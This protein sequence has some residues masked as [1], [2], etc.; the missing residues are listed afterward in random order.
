M[1]HRTPATLGLIILTVIA[2][3]VLPTFAGGLDQ[4]YYDDNDWVTEQLTPND[5]AVIA[6]E[7]DGLVLAARADGG[8][9]LIT[10]Y[11]H[12]PVLVYELSSA[13]YVALAQAG[14]VQPDPLGICAGAFAAARADGGLEYWK[15]YFDPTG[16]GIGSW[17]MEVISPDTY[18]A[19]ANV[20]FWGPFLAIRDDGSL[21]Y[22]DIGG[23]SEMIRV[24]LGPGPYLA[25][26]TG[27]GG[28]IFASRADGGVDRFV[29]NVGPTWNENELVETIGS[30]M[31]T[32]MSMTYLYS[33]GP[34]CAK[35]GGGLYRIDRPEGG[36]NL[37]LIFLNSHEYTALYPQEWGDHAGIRADGTLEVFDEYGETF[38]VVG[39]GKYKAVA[40][41]VAAQVPDP[42][43]WP[44]D[45]NKDLVVDI[46]DLN[47]I[48]IAWG[49]TVQEYP[50][51]VPDADYDGNGVIN[52]IDLNAVL[53]DWGKTGYAQ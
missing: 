52:M 35:E 15:F 8:L 42:E 39:T 45:R 33:R 13:E 40:E 4:F 25:A 37:E 48:L 38:E 9:D 44:G 46:T 41:G 29:I 34:I 6:G 27:G 36:D 3:L 22:F 17:T 24:T 30:D 19:F 51:V 5:Y 14:W 43:Y 26:A 53:I 2:A 32:S 10:T 49:K 28:E 16:P 31:F 47:M 11:T 12:L 21:E 23:F 50:I 18:V 20:N 1:L 7:D